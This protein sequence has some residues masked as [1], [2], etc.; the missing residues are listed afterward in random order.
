VKHINDQLVRL[1]NDYI[2]KGISFVAISSND[3]ETQPDDSPEYMK[4]ILATEL[5]YPFPY[6]YDETQEVAKA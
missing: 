4:E 2:P 5:H 6:L 3:V 1:A